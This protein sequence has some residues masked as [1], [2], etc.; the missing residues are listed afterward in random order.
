MATAQL[1]R[2]AGVSRMRIESDDKTSFIELE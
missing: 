1:E 2:I